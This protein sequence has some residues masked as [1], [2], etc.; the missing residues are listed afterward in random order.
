MDVL[1]KIN[2]KFK[3]RPIDLIGYFFMK[4]FGKTPLQE[5]ET[6]VKQFVKY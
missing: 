4:L 3:R 6:G 5:F 1:E 2:I